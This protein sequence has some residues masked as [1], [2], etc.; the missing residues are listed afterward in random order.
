MGLKQ[1]DR[2]SPENSVVLWVLP[3]GETG[4]LS[5]VALPSQSERSDPQICS[6]SS[7]PSR[8]CSTK[9]TG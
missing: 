8:D 5:L 9:A 3:Q 7:F 1:G 6:I 2:G 4:C